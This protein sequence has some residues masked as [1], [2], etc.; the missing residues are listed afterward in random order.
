VK[1]RPWLVTGATGL[2]GGEVTARLRAYGKEVVGVGSADLD[3]THEAAVRRQLTSLVPAVVVNCAAWTAVDDA[4]SQEERALAVNGAGPAHLAAAC[5]ATGARLLH[6]STDYVFDGR[7]PHPCTEDAPTGPRTA[8][9]RTKLAG[10]QAVLT[11]L[12]HAGWVVRTGWLYGAG[13]ANFVR[14]MIRL[15]HTRDTIDVVN[16][17]YGQPTWTADLADRLVALGSTTL[18]GHPA[19]SGVYHGT[20][21][22]RTTW[23]ELARAVFTL[24]GADPDRIRPVTTA[25]LARPAARPAY[26]VLG[27][28]RWRTAGLEP[29]RNWRTALAEAF[30][31]LLA[32]ERVIERT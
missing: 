9:G 22:G 32:A 5:A 24:L 28:D 15:E 8:Y 6:V 21:A 31:H 3:I 4:E 12:P 25:G 26:S 1:E 11:I 17:Q 18:T 13:G 16:D 23:Y 10:E 30:P 19:P 14:T 2:L 27:H 29:L 20:S 7:S